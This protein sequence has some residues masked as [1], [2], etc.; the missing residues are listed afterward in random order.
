M[1]GNKMHENKIARVK[2]DYVSLSMGML[3]EF[4]GNKLSLYISFIK[5]IMDTSK[6]F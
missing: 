4:Y 2:N 3:S 1:S 5:L 6:K